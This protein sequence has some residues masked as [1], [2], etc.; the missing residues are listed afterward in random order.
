MVS[1]IAI[2]L[3]R[4][5]MDVDACINAY[6]MLSKDIFSQKGLPVNWQGEVT[7]RY[8]SSELEKSIIKIIG[9]TELPE[10]ALLNDGED[11]G[12]RV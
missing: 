5:H 3:G 8:K 11:R 2:M 4:L 1:L 6:S 10:D 12:C 7:G 9:A